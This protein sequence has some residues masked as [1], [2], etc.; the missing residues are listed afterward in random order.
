MR[1][2]SFLAMLA[3]FVL[4]SCQKDQLGL[5]TKNP[6][7]GLQDLKLNVVKS[8]L[9]LDLAKNH[10]KVIFKNAA[11]NEKALQ[12]QYLE[13]HKE[14]DHQGHR[15]KSEHIS[16]RYVDNGDSSYELKT[17]A[18]ANYTQDGSNEFVTSQILTS[19]NRGYIPMLS[20]AADKSPLICELWASVK[21]LDRTFKDVYTN[22][23]ADLE[24]V[25][26]F[27]KL[28]YTTELGIVGFEGLD[29]EMWVLDRFEE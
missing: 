8:Y 18:S 3:L 5:A 29:G 23:P 1:A 2:I 7:D 4:V 21:I 9:P 6:F 19:I 25:T 12:I 11:G 10:R 28:Y 26:S 14:K 24:F 20:I 15:Y 16:I 27:S 17:I 13:E 22:F